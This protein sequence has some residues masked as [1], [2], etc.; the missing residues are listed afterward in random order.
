MFAINHTRS[1]CAWHKIVDKILCEATSLFYV[2]ASL[3]TKI[4][5]KLLI[6]ALNWRTGKHEKLDDTD[7]IAE[8][9]LYA[10]VRFRV[11]Q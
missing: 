2:H 8:L 3:P 5:N 4:T 10:R 6:C 11:D 9:Q 1:A 7:H